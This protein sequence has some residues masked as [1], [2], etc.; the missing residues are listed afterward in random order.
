MI[1]TLRGVKIE[2]DELIISDM[3][4]ETCNEIDDIIEDEVDDIMSLEC[5]ECV[6]ENEEVK[7]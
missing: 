7:E 1:F 5:G 6:C 2:A 3:D 4:C